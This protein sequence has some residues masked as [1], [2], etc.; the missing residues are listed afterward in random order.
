M[1]AEANKAIIRQLIE[2]CVNRDRPE[3]LDRFAHLDVRVHPG[4][5]GTAPT[6]E[7]LGE[8]RQAF[9][10]FHTVFP[11]LRIT[12]EDEV[13]EGDRVAVRWTATGTHRAE[14]AGIAPS[15]KT[16][17]WGGIDI[18]RLA[19]GKVAEWWRNDDFVWLLSQLGQDVPR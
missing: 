7:G 12:A 10:R 3:L 16:V 15:G 4:T 19:D 1:A 18:Y 17:S 13:G 2:E 9:G 11:D 6:T 5:P 14:L 8:L